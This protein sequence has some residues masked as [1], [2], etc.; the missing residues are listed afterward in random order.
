MF[1]Y[2]VVLTLPY[3]S[4]YQIEQLQHL[5]V[6]KGREETGGLCKRRAALKLSNMGKV[7]NKLG[8]CRRKKGRYFL[9]GAFIFNSG[10]PHAVPELSPFHQTISM[11]R[12]T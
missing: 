4:S 7:S 12:Y 2:Y 11:L 9:I 1:L 8:L 3:A 5:R 10:S 6:Q